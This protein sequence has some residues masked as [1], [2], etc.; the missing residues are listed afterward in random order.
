MEPSTTSLEERVASY[1]WPELA[2]ELDA[3]G[4]ACL[5][6]LLS[7]IE[8]REVIALYGDSLHFRSRVLM[9]RH[10]FGRGEYQYF[11]HPLPPIVAQLRA[12]SW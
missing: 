8:C 3:R 6:A 5:N 4:Y 11:A 9:A 1:A 10:G 12:A 2:N 7:P